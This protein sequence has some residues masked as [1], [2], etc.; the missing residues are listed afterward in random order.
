[1]MDGQ[2]SFTDYAPPKS[3]TDEEVLAL[4]CEKIEGAHRVDSIVKCFPQH[5]QEAVA[6]ATILVG[7]LRAWRDT[8]N[9]SIFV[10]D[11]KLRFMSAYKRE[12]NK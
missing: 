1:M 2:L 11:I 8:G 7:G 4:W 5:Q 12:Q 10:Q 6:M 3:L 9:V